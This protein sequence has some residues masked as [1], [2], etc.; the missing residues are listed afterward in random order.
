MDELLILIGLCWFFPCL[1]ALVA[2]GKWNDRRAIALI[3]A[4]T[5][6]LAG[7]FLAL[8]VLP[9]LLPTTAWLTALNWNWVGKLGAI[10]VTLL[11]YALMSKPLKAEA[12]LFALPRPPE[13]RSVVIVS[14][15]LCA[16]FWSV[17]WSLET[18]KP[19]TAETIAFQATMPGLD[20]E[21][22]FRGVLL[23]LLV[24][25]LGKPYRFAGI[26]IGW[27]ALPIIAF[28]G[29]AHAVEAAG[30]MPIDW[31]SI[32]ITFALTGMTGVGLLW[33][34]ERTGSILVPIVVHNLINVGSQIVTAS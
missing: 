6:S 20:E 4:T 23:A 19:L 17:A 13:W 31:S 9:G 18:P 7:N 10:A 25:A 26:S 12:G 33:L 2:A 3:V 34:K 16:L 1:V 5:V 27:G 28:F 22:S 24:G 30:A 15:L 29:L 32:A 8:S 21:A 11:T 14:L